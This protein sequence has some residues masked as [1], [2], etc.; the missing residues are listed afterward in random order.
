MICKH[1]GSLILFNTNADSEC[2]NADCKKKFKLKK[3]EDKDE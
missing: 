1:C 3:D 2:S